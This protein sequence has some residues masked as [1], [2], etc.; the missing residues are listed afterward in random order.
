MNKEYLEDALKKMQEDLFNV[1]KTSQWNGKKYKN[2]QTAKTSYIRAKGFI[3]PIN[4]VL[5]K[6]FLKLD[7]N[8]KFKPA[9]N[10]HDTKG[11]EEVTGFMKKK[12][13]DLSIRIKKNSKSINYPLLIN[14]RSQMSKISGN[15]DTIFERAYAESINLKMPINYIVGEVF[16]LPYYEFNHKK[17]KY[18]KIEY[19]KDRINLDWFFSHYTKVNSREDL[20][21][22]GKDF[23]KY[24]KLCILII[25]F[26]QTPAK[27]VTDFGNKS[28]NKRY[29]EFSYEGF[30]EYLLS[31]YKK[32]I[33]VD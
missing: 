1:I 9:I 26:K 18:N 14:T 4:D 8:L 28:L 6:S 5:K 17:C 16:V 33:N 27:I 21:V 30:C 19:L 3:N 25:D 29:K 23:V 13:Q 11:E 20:N 12:K 2:G 32:T 7:S 22:E 31:K 10:S 24:D 15:Q